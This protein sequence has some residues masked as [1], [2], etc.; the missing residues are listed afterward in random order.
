M[1]YLLKLLSMK[2]LIIPLLLFISTISFSQVGI[3]TIQFIADSSSILEI[4]DTA[5][6]VLLPKLYWEQISAI[7]RPSTGLLLFRMD[8]DIGFYYFDGYKWI[9]LSNQNDKFNE[10]RIQTQMYFKL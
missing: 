1:L 2:L 3:G 8:G 4:R 9:Q 6:G 7:K 10:K 5:R